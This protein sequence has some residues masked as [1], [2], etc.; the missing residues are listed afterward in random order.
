[1]LA[2][3]P[4]RPG[5]RLGLRDRATP[6]STRVSST[7][8]SGW[9]SRVMTG[10]ARWVNSSVCSPTRRPR[11]PCARSGPPPPGRSRSAR[12][13]V[14]AR[15]RADPAL[16]LGALAVAGLDPG[17]VPT[18]VIS[19]R[20][21][22]T[23]TPVEPVVGQSP[24]EPLGASS[25]SGRSPC[26]QPPGRPNGPPRRPRP[27]PKPGPKPGPKP[28]ANGPP[29]PNG[30]GPKPGPKGPPGPRRPP[31]RPPRR[32]SRSSRES[33]PPWRSPCSPCSWC[34]WCS[35]CS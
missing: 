4:H 25:A 19:S 10:T 7:S 11:R 28:W 34:S 20:S 12:S 22:V 2:D 3:D 13:R 32:S 8:R 14:S 30:P 9:R 21:T 5:E 27:R 15:K 16:G 26:C 31:R 35:W 18:T 17:S 6:A 1:M 33:R 23:S 24:G 29:G